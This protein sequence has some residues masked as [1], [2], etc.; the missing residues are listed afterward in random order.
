MNAA[1]IH[2]ALQA[3]TACPVG[4]RVAAAYAA[5][6]A[7]SQAAHAYL[8]ALA[9][10]DALRHSDPA[11][12]WHGTGQAYEAAFDALRI[13]VADSIHQALKG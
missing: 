10:V 13:A 7:V 6:P 4:Y 3:L 2:P 8:S 9:A 5:I 1:T 11:A 12:V